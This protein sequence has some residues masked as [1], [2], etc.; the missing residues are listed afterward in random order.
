ML[1]FKLFLG[2]IWEKHGC[3]IL[4]VS[5]G[6]LKLTKISGIFFFKYSFK[7]KLLLIL[8]QYKQFFFSVFITYF[9]FLNLWLFWFKL[10]WF[11]V[12]QSSFFPQIVETVDVIIFDSH[13]LWKS[14]ELTLVNFSEKLNNSL[15]NK[16]KHGLAHNP[17]KNEAERKRGSDPHARA[18][19]RRQDHH[20]QKVHRGGHHKNIPNF[21]VQHQDRGAPRVQD[22]HMGRGRP[23]VIE[24]VLEKLLWE[25]RWFGVGGGFYW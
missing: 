4:W 6:I 14:P 1:D 3:H 16:H 15:K 13:R 11:W 10:G 24:V 25:H 17:Q 2:I 8:I 20:T 22:E 12:T 21:R 23:E 5:Q 9:I 7:F 19:Q 18:W